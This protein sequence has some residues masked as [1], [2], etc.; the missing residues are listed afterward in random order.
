MITDP[1]SC[2]NNATTLT[3]G[4]FNDIV[5]VNAPSGQ[6]WT[7]SANTGF[8]LTS[9]PA[10]PAAPL[11]IP[12]GTAMTNGTVDGINNDGDGQTD[13]A[14]ENVYYTLRGVHVDALGYNITV[15]N[16]LGTSSS[17]GSTCYYPNPSINGLA[18]TFCL[19]D[20]VV[21]LSGS[22]QLGMVPDQQWE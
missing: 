15:T 7:V 5:T 3:N 22:A 2:K 11:I 10:P 18:N 16:S 17:I 6:N 8:Y 21:T 4:Q 19:N 1:C 12:I 14:D 13:E 9:S 20:P